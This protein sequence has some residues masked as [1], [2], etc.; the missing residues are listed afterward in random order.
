M[1]ISASVTSTGSA[2]ATDRRLWLGW[3]AGCWYSLELPRI[4]FARPMFRDNSS[5]PSA[6][7]ETAKSP[8]PFAPSR[9]RVGKLFRAVPRAAPRAFCG[10][11]PA[12]NRRSCQPGKARIPA[13][14]EVFP[15][16]VQPGAICDGLPRGARN[17]WLFS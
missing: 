5:S 16:F 8:F 15:T 17:H 4:L 12:P 9:L 3:R 7:P 10:L 13:H 14:T 2:I 11:S 1:S 6:H